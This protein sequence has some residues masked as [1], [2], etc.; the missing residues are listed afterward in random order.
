MADQ[1][2]EVLTP[3][4][5]TLFE[6]APGLYLV[7][8][9][10]FFIVAASDAYLRA[11][12]TDRAAILGKPVF[13]VFPDNPTDASAT[14]VQNLRA[15]L[16]RVRQYHVPDTMPLQRY[17]IRQPESAGGVFEEH[18]WSPI[19]SPVLGPD[20]TLLY[21]IHRV[22]NMTELVRLQRHGGEQDQR[23]EALLSRVEWMEGELYRSVQA[24]HAARREAETQRE[25]LYA[26]F[27][28]APAAIS[29]VRGPDMNYELAN[30][31]FQQLVGS[32][33][34]LV[35][36]P[37]LEAMPDVDG[38]LHD[39]LKRAYMGER[40]VGHEYPITL[41]WD[42]NNQPYQKFMNFVYEPLRQDDGTIDGVI[43]FAYDVT[44]QVQARRTVEQRE[45]QLRAAL[46]DAEA[47]QRR[48]AFLAAASAELNMVFDYETVLGRI[49]QLAVPTLADWC[50]FDVITDDG[51]TKRVAWAHVDPALQ[52]QF[53]Q[54]TQFAPPLTALN[55]PIARTLA[56]GTTE[57]KTGI[58]DEWLQQ[59]ATSSQHYQY[60]RSLQFH[61]MLNVP[62]IS[63]ERMIGALTFC[64]IDPQRQY[65]AVDRELAEELARRAALTIEN[66]RLYAA[67][68]QAR[69]EAETAVRV[70]DEF[71]SVASHELKTPVTSMRGYASLLLNQLSKGREPDPQRLERALNTITQQ[72]DKLTCFIDQLLDV[73][74]IASNRLV[75]HREHTNV[76]HLVREIVNTLQQT[77]HQHELH[78]QIEGDTQA[79]VD[80]LR[81]EQVITNLVTNAIK[82]SPSGGP[83]KID[84]QRNT[85]STLR[86]TVTDY[87]IGIP[88]EHRAHIF[89]RFYQAHGQGY[90]GG[91]GLGLSISQHIVLLHGGRLEAEFPEAGGTRMVVVLPVD[92]NGLSDEQAEQ[93]DWQIANARD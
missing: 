36:K 3:D 49:A 86:I 82:Y 35:G 89:E 8:T 40:F 41:D 53:D 59:I 19:N 22:E 9:P 72:S 55:N 90:F 38:G 34:P 29:V 15:S 42:Y 17:D 32:N 6:S 27:M 87:G 54:V 30:P 23:N 51:L 70:R 92:G 76:G 63:R 73:S 58:T 33:R 74:R 1:R 43:S 68:Q 66:A 13:D 79:Y 78:I 57:I 69:A 83:V 64:L 7:L 48:L 24:V 84:V 28:Q 46:A 88:V 80:P 75:L 65:T 37:L 71:L 10:D 21:I 5:R 91:M 60:M 52:A 31:S 77:T 2:A 14:G 45:D 67:E 26:V 93:T 47:A 62:V 20:N 25:R 39:I 61:T 50:F 56:H 81:L 4:F 11:T 18:Y 85:L 44:D 16:E 12:Y